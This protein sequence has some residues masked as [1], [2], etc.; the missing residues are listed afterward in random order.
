MKGAHADFLLAIVAVTAR[1]HEICAAGV[2]VLNR[3]Y[4]ATKMFADASL[5][6]ALDIAVCALLSA[7]A[8][9]R[10]YNGTGLVLASVALADHPD[11]ML[12]LIMYTLMQHIVAPRVGSMIHR[13]K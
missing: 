11:V 10:I 13:Q 9:D 6:L 3:A 4:E 2:Q 7:A 1:C 12:P 5:S 8:H